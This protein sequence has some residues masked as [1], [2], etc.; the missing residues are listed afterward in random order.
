MVQEMVRQW[1]QEL[2]GYNYSTWLSTVVVLFLLM[3]GLWNGR[4]WFVASREQKAQFAM[5][6]AFE[7]YDRAVYRMI[8]SKQKDDQ[9][10]KQQLEDA[11][12][13]LDIVIRNHGGSSTLPACAHAFKADV[14]WYD[15]KKDE[16]IQEMDYA[17][18][19]ASKSSL[20]YPWKTKVALMKLDGGRE[21]EGI[22]ELSAL[23]TDVKNPTADRAAFDLGYYYWCN[24]DE[25]KARETWKL[26][27][28]FEAQKGDQ[29]GQTASPYLAVAQMKL[30]HISE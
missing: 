9:V 14:Y 23:A 8:D 19:G 24:K 21:Q 25:A 20:V 4:Q 18:K 6:E 3:L 15:G 1:W 27:E 10:A 5:S 12:L 30:G 17:I 7:E 22:A 16:A 2:K 29:F 11:L 13:S 26:L 28:K